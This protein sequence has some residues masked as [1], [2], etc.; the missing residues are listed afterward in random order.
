MNTAIKRKDEYQKDELADYKEQF[1]EKAV[2]D[3]MEVGAL[4]LQDLETDFGII[5]DERERRRQENQVIN[6]HNL[7]FYRHIDIKVLS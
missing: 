4:D 6:F 3:V 2:D 1:D 7:Q 5:E